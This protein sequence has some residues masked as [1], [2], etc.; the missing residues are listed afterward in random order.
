MSASL[1]YMQK[2]ILHL[3]SV[4]RKLDQSMG[5]NHFLAEGIN[6]SSPESKQQRPEQIH[7]NCV[8]RYL[9][10]TIWGGPTM[11]SEDQTLW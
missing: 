6:P 2:R 8:T 5:Q 4:V 3:E 9:G 11:P 7:E 1:F 10:S